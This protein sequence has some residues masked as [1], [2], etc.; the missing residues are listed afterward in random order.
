MARDINTI[1]FAYDSPMSLPDRVKVWLTPVNP[2]LPKWPAPVDLTVGDIQ[3][4]ISAEWLEIA[5]SAQ[6]RAYRKPLK[7]LFQIVP[8][9]TPYNLLF[10]QIVGHKCTTHSQV[11]YECCHLVNINEWCRLL[12]NY[13]GPCLLGFSSSVFCVFS[14]FSSNFVVRTTES[15][16]IISMLELDRVWCK[17][18]SSQKLLFLNRIWCK[19]ANK[20]LWK[21]FLCCNIFKAASFFLS[22]AL[23]K[24]GRSLYC[25]HA[26]QM[27]EVTGSFIP[28]L[29]RT[30]RL[31]DWLGAAVYPNM[32]LSV[33][34]LVSPKWPVKC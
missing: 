25:I 10:P 13:F 14:F 2:F 16:G 3:Q 32:S 19:Y 4:K 31:I 6:C 29:C 30:S 15:F 8:S 12:P 7:L 20:F 34:L 5:Q 23:N 18:M 27:Q 21:G 24:C 28:A 22:G 17:N 26:E 11:W 1:S 9:L 33:G